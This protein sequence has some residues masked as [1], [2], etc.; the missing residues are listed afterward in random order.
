M[1]EVNYFNQFFCEDDNS[2][3]VIVEDDIEVAYAYLM[4]DNQII[5]DV[6]LYNNNGTPDKVDWS[7]V[8]LMPFKNPKN[9]INESM[10][11]EKIDSYDFVVEWTQ[12]GDAITAKVYIRGLALAYLNNCSKIGWSYAVSK[13]GPLAKKLFR[14]IIKINRIDN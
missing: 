11:M 1:R 10:M 6:W 7:D 3:S 4:R 2:Y 8:S 5:S 13:N 12:N 9:Y 14:K